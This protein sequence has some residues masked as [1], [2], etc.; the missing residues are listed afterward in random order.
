M[1]HGY[2]A[3]DK[4]TGAASIPKYQ[5]STFDLKKGYIDNTEY[6]YTRFSNPTVRALEEAIVSLEDSKFGF[7]FASGMGA[8][9]SAL[10]LAKASE[11]IIFPSDVYGGTYQF[12]TEIVPRYGIETSFVDYSDISNIEKA[13]NSKTKI[14]YIET[15]SNPLMKVSDIKQITSLA[16]KNGLL[17]IADNTF[18]TSLYQKPL[19]LGCD[20]VVESLTKFINGHSDVVGGLLAT[21]N[22][23][24]AEEITLFQKNF[25]AILGVEDAWLVLRG[26]KTMGI[27]MEKSIN[28]AS[29]IA[30]FLSKNPKI[31]TV[32]YP[33]LKYHQKNDIQLDQACNGGAVLSFELNN[34]SK[35]ASFVQSLKLPIY[36]VSLGG[37]ESILSH[38]AT[39]SHAC[40]SAEE[41]KKQGITD[42]L[43][44]LSCGIEETEDLIA[45]LT[46]ALEKI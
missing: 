46:Q 22:K 7:S 36:A 14:I 29:K 34:S 9:S 45:D 42:G 24:I 21:N 15:P 18:M 16:K 41:R 11:H 10:M 23:I 30:N 1:L 8:I 43:L 44:R 39:M 28:N 12:A 37:V 20:I 5:T 31:K 3:T 33:S 2:V 35:L 17:T 4:F 40:L 25:G 6:N 19:D 32:Y 26:I 13:I 38:P 27:R